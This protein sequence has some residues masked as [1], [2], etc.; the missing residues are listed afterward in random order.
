MVRTRIVGPVVVLGLIAAIAL[1]PQSAGATGGPVSQASQT[2]SVT[3]TTNPPSGADWFYGTNSFGIGY[4]V[5]AT[6]SSGLPVVLS[7][8]PESAGVCSIFNPF[9]DEG[10][11]PGHAYVNFSGAGT[12]TIDADQP[13]DATYLPA[14]TASQ[15][16]VIEKAPTTMWKPRAQKGL[17]GI[18]PTTFSATLERPYN[19]DSHFTGLEGFPQQTVTFALGGQPVCSGTT[20]AQGVASCTAMIRVGQWLP[21][22]RWTATYA[23][24]ALYKGSSVTGWLVG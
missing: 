4:E 9:S 20:D 19:V 22:L 1:L 14:P 24:D 18:T 5:R 11:T 2:Q 7:V 10:P 13:G 23:G 21:G 3:F 6:A 17:P 8:A 15:S 16:F 12:C